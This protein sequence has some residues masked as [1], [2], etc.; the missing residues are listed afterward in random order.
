MIG[1]TIRRRCRRWSCSARRG[2]RS[3]RGGGRGGLGRPSVGAA[4]PTRS[5]RRGR[6]GGDS[7]ATLND[8]VPRAISPSSAEIVVHGPRRTRRGPAREGRS[9]AIR[10]RDRGRARLRR[11]PC[12]SRHADERAAVRIDLLG[13]RAGHLGGRALDGRA[14]VGRRDVELGVRAGRMPG[15]SAVRGPLSRA[16]V[17]CRARVDRG[18]HVPESTEPRF[19][20]R[21]MAVRRRPG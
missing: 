19:P 16:S 4:R 18:P 9:M 15:R 5:G 21:S 14:V 20:G 2:V 11:R 7:T 6:S 13:E 10:R 12:P 17:M 8:H 3:G 1:R